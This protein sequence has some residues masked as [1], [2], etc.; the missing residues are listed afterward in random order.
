MFDRLPKFIFFTGKGGVGKTSLACA[1]ALKFADDNQRVLLV[2]TDLASNVG[3]V[4][5][6]VIG[7]WITAIGA[8]PGLDAIEIYPERA[9]EQ[10]RK[11]ILSP[12]RE[13]LP[14]EVLAS[15]TEQLSGLCTTEI[16][17][18]DEFTE[19]LIDETLAVMS[20]VE[21]GMVS[22]AIGDGRRAAQAIAAYLRDNTP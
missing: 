13:Q 20:A 16:A 4:F 12:V 6:S 14:A 1:S 3:Q 8:V 19:L 22:I 2:S 17:V 5:D 18:F 7:N 10:Y 9:A 21:W 11:R 15:M